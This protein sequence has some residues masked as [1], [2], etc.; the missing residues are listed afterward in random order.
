MSLGKNM[1]GDC[2]WSGH[3]LL[4][5]VLAAELLCEALCGSVYPTS[6]AVGLEFCIKWKC[7][8]INSH[9]LAFFLL[10]SIIEATFLYSLHIAAVKIYHRFSGSNQHKIIILLLA[11]EARNLKWICR[12]VFLLE[13]LGQNLGIKE[14]VCLVCLVF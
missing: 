9:L 11:P 2:G 4:A 1:E 8:S 10:F 14:I 12:I 6:G 3:V 5:P 7:N 13:T